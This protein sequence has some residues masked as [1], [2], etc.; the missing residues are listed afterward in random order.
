MDFLLQVNVQFLLTHKSFDPSVE[1]SNNPGFRNG[2]HNA[3]AMAATPI[4]IY[5]GLTDTFA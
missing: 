3:V 1:Y 2:R 4:C 5:D